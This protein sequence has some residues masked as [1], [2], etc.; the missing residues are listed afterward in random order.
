MIFSSK[1][2]ICDTL[3]FS[4][5]LYS[6][7]DVHHLLFRWNSVLV[8]HHRTPAEACREARVILAEILPILETL[9]H[10]LTIRFG[11]KQHPNARDERDRTENYCGHFRVKWV[12][13]RN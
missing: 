12:E 10:R 3:K 9:R 11:Q 4:K 5:L 7:V 8:P 6:F 2:R 1:Q 13:Q